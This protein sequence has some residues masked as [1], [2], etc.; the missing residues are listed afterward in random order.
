[1]YEVFYSYNY[2][3]GITMTP[4]YYSKDNTGTTASETGIGVK[5]TFSF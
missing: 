2:A 3:D 4:F 1:M 5:T